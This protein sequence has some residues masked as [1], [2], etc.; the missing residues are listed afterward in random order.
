MEGETA[1]ETCTYR[2]GGKGIIWQRVNS[3]DDDRW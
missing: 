1:W 2:Y 3:D